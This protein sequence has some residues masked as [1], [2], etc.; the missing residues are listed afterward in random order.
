MSACTCEWELVLILKPKTPATRNE[1][2]DVL[3]MGLFS[4]KKS[5]KPQN[6]SHSLIKNVAL[7][8]KIKYKETNPMCTTDQALRGLGYYL[9]IEDELGKGAFGVVVPC[10]RLDASQKKLPNDKLN[11]ILKRS[12]SDREIFACKIIDAANRTEKRVRDLNNE[13][14]ALQKTSH[15]FIIKYYDAFIIDTK[16]YI[17]MEYAHNG[18]LK[19]YMGKYRKVEE[20]KARRWFKQM[21]S[22]IKHLHGLGIAHRDLKGEN[23]LLA[24]QMFEGK[25]RRVCKLSDFGL[26]AVS[27]T[28]EEGPILVSTACGTRPYMAPEILD[29]KVRKEKP[30]DPMKADIWSIGVI[31]FQMITNKYPFNFENLQTMVDLQKRHNLDFSCAP[32]ASADVKDLIHQILNPDP[33]AR[34]TIIGIETHPWLAS[35]LSLDNLNDSSSS[36]GK[37]IKRKGSKNLIHANNDKKQ[38]KS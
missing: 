8:T 5:P 29:E 22:A 38:M 27:F 32:E 37:Q 35:S 34:L 26:S 18:H 3:A 12:I 23:V 11:L 24:R 7:T 4:R 36:S 14:S 20:R 17:I 15:P 9:D 1:W 19:H 10:W 16:F 6:K 21:L 30:Y 25:M 28:T 2:P 13:L 33:S 31:L